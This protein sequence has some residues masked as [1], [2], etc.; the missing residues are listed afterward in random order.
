MHRFGGVFI[1][2]C[3]CLAVAAVGCASDENEPSDS[4]DDKGENNV[5]PEYLGLK[6][7]KNGFQIR[8]KGAEVGSGEDVEYCEVAR[9]PGDADQKYF[10]NKLELGNQKGSHHLIVSAAVAGSAAEA[11]LEELGEGNRVPCLGA[12]SKFGPD[13]FVSV[14][15]SQQPY[16]EIVMPENVGREY[17]GGQYIVFDYHYL[18][19]RDEP[20]QAASAVNFHLTD[21]ASVKHIARGF[22]FSNYTLATA[23]GTEASYIGE[24]LFN[25]DVMLSDVTR[26]THR[27]GTDFAVWFVG[28]DRDGEEFW[29]SDD[30]QHNTTHAF[31]KPLRVSKGQGLR[32]RCSYNND[33]SHALR[34]GTSATDEMCILFGT[35][36]EANDGEELKS[37]S[38]SIVWVGE[39]GVG[40]SAIEAGGFPAPSQAEVNACM[41]GAGSDPSACTK[42]HCEACANPLIQCML[43]GDCK[44][45]SDCYT[46]CP[47]GTNC[48]STCDATVDAHSSGVGPITQMSSCFNTRC[49]E[50]C[51]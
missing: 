36:W 23:P 9:L 7:P 1:R 33:T 26:H 13:S 41:S 4:G 38:C 47:K 46:A 27:W 39:D 17:H 35:V 12:E 42:C 19:T 45:I 16:N 28:G 14:G 11:K 8:S 10:V 25:T 29:T 32:F 21:K 51:K 22:N 6:M 40:H 34:Y 15:G 18:N 44:A 50:E 24:C 48:N 30:W 3:V 31:D 2:C 43:D 49:A 37:Q 20:I 5:V